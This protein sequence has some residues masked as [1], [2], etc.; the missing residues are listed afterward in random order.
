MLYHYKFK[1]KEDKT[2]GEIKINE[3][4]SREVNC[5]DKKHQNFL[6]LLLSKILREGFTLSGDVVFKKPVRIGDKDFPRFL[7]QY[8]L[9]WGYSLEKI[10]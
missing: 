9:P 7:E 6:V 4:G 8:L 1:N 3:K 5:T 2:E 10:K